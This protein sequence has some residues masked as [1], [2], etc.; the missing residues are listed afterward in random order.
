MNVYGIILAAGEAK[1]ASGRKLSKPVMG[2][3]MLEWVVEKATQ[4]HL[5]G[6]IMVAGKEKELAKDLAVLYGIDYVY[7]PNYIHGMSTS[8]KMGVES[9]PEDADGFAVLLGD[10]PFIRI[11]TINRIIREFVREQGIVVPVFR[12]R[13]G[14]PPVFPVS[15]KKE[16]GLLEGDEG[17]RS[18]IQDCRHEVRLLNT[19]DRGVVLDIDCFP[20]HPEKVL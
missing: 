15:F 20:F 17:A 10:M 19:Q 12:G 9:L 2:K 11:E 1:R 14:H 8:L 7:N 6:I 16:I 5:A 3:P 18:I 4:S 13:R